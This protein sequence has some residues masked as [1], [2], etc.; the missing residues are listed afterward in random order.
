MSLT[1]AACEILNTAAP[2]AKA[3]LSRETAAVWRAGAL[4]GIGMQRPVARPARPD[5]PALLPPQEMPRRR[6]AAGRVA[7]LHAIAHIEFNAI[8]LAWDMIARFADPELPRTFYDDWV[9]VGDEEAKHF[10][11]LSQRLDAL[12]TAYGDLPAHDGLWRAAQATSHDVLARLAVAPL[13]LE[14]RGLDVTPSMIERLEKA[15]DDDSVAIL[16]IILADEIGH[17]AAGQRWFTHIAAARKLEPAATFHA[18]VRKHYHGRLK[19]PFNKA[20]RDAAGF[21]VDWYEPLATDS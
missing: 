19:P 20:G 4:G 6:G 9:K 18:L 11:L 17:V 3:A 8:D 12:D 1:G 2:A 21:H 14:A 7:L 15:G 13:V 16:Q 5:R 10:M